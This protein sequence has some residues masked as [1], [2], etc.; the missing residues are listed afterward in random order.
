MKAVANSHNRLGRTIMALLLV[1]SLLGI[2]GCGSTQAK[3]EKLREVEFT[4]LALD[5]LP[6]EIQQEIEDR[7]QEEFQSTFLTEEY[8]VFDTKLVGPKEGQKVK[9]APSY[10]IVAVKTEA[11][12]KNVIYQ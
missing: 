11:I 10:P 2:S 3:Q 5:E 4:V 8:M 7:S 9:E 6:E 1:L 12:D